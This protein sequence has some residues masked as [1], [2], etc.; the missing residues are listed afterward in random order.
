MAD[1]GI[2]SSALCSGA[3]AADKT[4]AKVRTYGAVYDPDRHT[5]FAA[6]LEHSGAASEQLHLLVKML[7][8]FEHDRTESLILSVHMSRDGGN[9]SVLLSS[10]LSLG[11][12]RDCCPK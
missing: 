12:K 6:V 9:D 10:E 5:L 7:A 1:G 11:V 2:G 4:K 3:A 8:K